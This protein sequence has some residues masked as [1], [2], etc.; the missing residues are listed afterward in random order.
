MWIETTYPSSSG[1]KAF[2]HLMVAQDT[3]TAIKGRVRGD[4]F[5]GTGEEAA[6]IAGHMKQPGRMVA[7]L[8]KP[9]ARRLGLGSP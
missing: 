4:V 7:L 1:E 6:Y 5:W 2:R 9:V 8:P 3:G